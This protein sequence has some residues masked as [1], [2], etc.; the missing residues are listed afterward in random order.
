MNIYIFTRKHIFGYLFT[1]LLATPQI[2]SS[3]EPAWVLI[4]TKVAVVKIMVGDKIVAE[5]DN[6]S[7]GQRGAEKL[8]LRGDQTTPLGSYRITAIDH[9]SRYRLF[10]GLNYPTAEHA[11]FALAQKKISPR[12]YQR[13][14]AAHSKGTIPPAN[15]D[16]GGEIGI[17]GIG[18]G[19]LL[20][21]NQYNWTN[22]CVALDNEQIE[23]F[24]RR[25]DIGTRV[26]IQ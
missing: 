15:T 11:E 23:D 22:G 20:V 9:D 16:L 24:A 10:F 6:I 2:S 7:I 14:V 8:H 17:H 13:I 25:V 12:D 5:Y 3:V 4:D 21:H 1:L 18:S 26:I 19:S